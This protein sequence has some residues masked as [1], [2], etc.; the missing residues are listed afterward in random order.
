MKKYL[1]TLLIIIGALSA[2]TN[3]DQID[4]QYETTFKLMPSSVISGFKEIQSGDFKISGDYKL[5]TSL[6]IYDKSG[7]LVDK[8]VSYLDNYTDE[9]NVSTPL[10]LG[11][12]IG[13]ATA[14]I[15]KYTNSNISL[16]YW[17]FKNPEKL[18]TFNIVDAG[19]RGGS[20]KILGV[21][22]MLFTV[23][24]KSSVTIPIQPSGCLF[25][26]IFYGIH[27]WSSIITMGLYYSRSNDYLL[28]NET[29]EP[30]TKI[31]SKGTYNYI[32]T[33]LDLT[34]GTL[35]NSNNVY[36]YNFKLPDPEF[37]LKLGIEFFDNSTIYS[38][39]VL[40]N[41]E[42]GQQYLFTLNLVDFS[43]E[44]TLTNGTTKSAGSELILPY[45]SK[46]A[47]KQ[48]FQEQVKAATKQ[49]LHVQDLVKKHK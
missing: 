38:D 24:K 21:S 27:E 40:V 18:N 1:F 31:I 44:L 14:D 32:L 49:T 46:A 11:E 29:G 42:A 22:S 7:I 23:D 36:D 25:A 19:Y 13:V 48:M 30:D 47:K 9:M 26:S 12:Y 28:F 39:P 8:Q 20:D 41:M 3:E 2:C 6:F 15:V 10:P 37:S 4:I 16:E 34:D 5:R 43:S 17:F 35:D 45:V 33:E